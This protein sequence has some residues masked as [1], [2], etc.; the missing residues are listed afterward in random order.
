MK[1]NLADKI[2]IFDEAHNIEK[3]IEEA[4]SYQFSLASLN[5]CQ[6]YFTKINDLIRQ[7]PDDKQ[8]LDLEIRHVEIPVL[9]LLKKFTAIKKNLE[10]KLKEKL[11]H[12]K[13]ASK[14]ERYEIFQNNKLEVLN[15]REIFY[16][17]QNDMKGMPLKS[18]LLILK[19]D[20]V[21]PELLSKQAQN[22]INGIDHTNFQSFL[23]ILD[24]VYED[25]KSK[26]SQ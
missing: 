12:T 9:N 6:V 13:A 14:E 3:Q 19:V 26:I 8:L 5:R 18:I 20:H 7:N 1:I 16:Y 11:P 2:I 21:N 22:F 15:G 17:F 23:E 10:R 25:E 24:H 4:N